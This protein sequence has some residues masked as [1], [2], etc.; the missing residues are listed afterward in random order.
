[1][2]REQAIKWL[3][4]FR[5]RYGMNELEDAVEMAIKELEAA[6]VLDKISAEIIKKFKNCN[7]CDWFE[8]YDYEEN[9][10]S[11]YRSVGDIS[12][13]IEIINK[14]KAESEEEE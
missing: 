7:I 6:D 4:T 11:E 2:T 3:K 13:I 12:D 9:D 8:D 10:I 14:Y 5:G 1:M